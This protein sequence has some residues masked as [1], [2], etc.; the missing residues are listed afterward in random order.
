MICGAQRSILNLCSFMKYIYQEANYVSDLDAGGIVAIHV[1][2]CHLG[3][4]CGR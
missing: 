4:Q 1:G 2:D 3:D